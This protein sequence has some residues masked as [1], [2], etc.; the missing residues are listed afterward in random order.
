MKTP[1]Q[2]AGVLFMLLS[3]LVVQ[4]SLRLQYYTSLGPG[5]G[6]FPLWVGGAVGVMGAL[7]LYQATFRPSEPMPDDFVP[8]SAGYLRMGAIVLSLVG[9]VV[10]MDPLGFRLTMLAF[11]VVLLSALGR[12]N[13]LVTA[14]V[15]LTGSF[16]VY[17]A[18][19]EWLK[20]VLPIG[21]LGI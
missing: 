17:F 14:L 13:I 19:V 6:F 12:Q 10:L 3:A 21:V 7:T 18:F 1:Y 20:V 9:A 16:G 11:L 4:Q 2:V 5:P 8:S 15:A